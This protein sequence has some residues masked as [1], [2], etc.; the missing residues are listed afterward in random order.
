[1]I[2]TVEAA[3][4]Q[5]VKEAFAWEE[6]SEYYTPTRRTHTRRPA[7]V[8]AL[9]PDI[10]LFRAQIE[11]LEQRQIPQLVAQYRDEDGGILPI[12]LVA[13]LLDFERSYVKLYEAMV[14]SSI[15]TDVAA[16][17][18][19]QEILAD[20]MSEFLAVRSSGG[21]GDPYAA[22]T[23][24]GAATT[25]YSNRVGDTVIYC[26]GYFVSTAAGFGTSTPASG[27]LA[28]GRYSFGIIDAGT[29]RFEGIVWS[30]P[31]QVRLSLP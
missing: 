13:D 25:V 23:A 8:R 29:Q 21:G 24:A 7:L 28:Q 20:R 19:A 5:A 27:T 16:P 22:S 18:Q 31:A 11:E 17:A 9:A 12:P 2:P 14:A 3:L 10:A 30:C 15:K 4:R 1:M 26:K 6:P